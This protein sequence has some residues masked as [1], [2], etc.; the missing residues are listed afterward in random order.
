[1]N[2]D[3]KKFIEDNINA[4]DEGDWY[5]VFSTWYDHVWS[6]SGTTEQLLDVFSSCGISPSVKARENI[7]SDRLTEFFQNWIQ[8]I[9]QRTTNEKRLNVVYISDDVIHNYLGLPPSVVDSLIH[10]VAKDFPEII[11]DADH[12]NYEVYV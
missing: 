2:Y 12:N 5:E 1:M 7:I 11:F 4:I 3:V 8:D 10:E 9:K 6:G